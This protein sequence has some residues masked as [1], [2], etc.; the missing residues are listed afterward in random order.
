MNLVN[1]KIWPIIPLQTLESE[2]QLV[3]YSLFNQIKNDNIDIKLS[4][5]SRI[6]NT[7]SRIKNVLI[8][9]PFKGSIKSCGLEPNEMADVLYVTSGIIMVI[10]V[11]IVCLGVFI[12]NQVSSLIY[13]NL[14]KHKLIASHN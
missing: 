11:L 14:I 13:N 9:K 12:K 8:K 3:N 7:F 10:G 1:S 6:L 4:K 5:Y 2:Y